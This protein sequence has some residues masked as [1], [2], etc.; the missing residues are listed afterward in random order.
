MFVGI[1][2]VIFSYRI[3]FNRSHV[4]AN[5]LMGLSGTLICIFG[6]YKIAKLKE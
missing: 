6:S 1:L 4:I 5:L 3:D 2:M